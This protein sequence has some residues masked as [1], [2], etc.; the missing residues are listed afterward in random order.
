MSD[1]AP[2]APIARKPVVYRLPGMDAVRVQRDVAYKDAL[3]MDI[4]H[5]S[6]DVDGTGA[7]AVLFVT[8]YPDAGMRRALGCY[9]KEM[10]SYVT[11][12]RLVA[13]SGM[14]AI[15]Y[16]NS[17]PDVD[18]HDLL[19]HLRANAGALGIDAGRLGVWSCS[20]SVPNALSLLMTDRGL[21]CAALC[22]GYLL[23][24]DPDLN[25]DLGGATPVADAAKQFRFVNTAAGRSVDDLPRDLPLLVVR[26]GR[27][28]MPHLNDAI[29][30]FVPHALRANL[31]LTLIN[32][33]TGVHAFDLHDDTA[34]SRLVIARILAFL[35]MHLRPAT[36][37]TR[38]DGG[39]EEVGFDIS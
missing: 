31:P 2:C 14:T 32:H 20:G 36:M 1:E 12:A 4:Y 6:A 35:Q 3:T 39:Q 9:T 37:A 7:P 23:D 11:W 18:V 10:A 25:L 28:E 21:A 26:A 13:A 19:R 30:A 38:L 34:A 22:Y 17:Q 24:L 27:D 16:V 8:G 5:A 15:T 33:H 29:D